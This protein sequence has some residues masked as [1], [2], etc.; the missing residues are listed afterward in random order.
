MK[1]FVV[2]IV[3]GLVLAGLGWS[4][5]NRLSEY[6][7]GATADRSRDEAPVEVRPVERG[8]IEL[9]RIFSGTLESTAE[10]VVAPKVGGRVERMVV[11][12]ADLVTRGQVVAE[13]DNDEFEQELAQAEAERVVARAKVAEAKSRLEITERELA[14]ARKLQQ[15][16]LETE[17]RFD[18]VEAER[19]AAQAGLE[20]ARAQETRAESLLAGA[21]I[22]L[23]YTRVT[24]SWTGDVDRR[25]VAR[26]HVDE[27]EMVAARTPLFTIVELDPIKAVVSVT[28]KDYA[29]L[30][31]G[32][33]AVLTT[34]AHPDRTFQGTIARIAPVFRQTSRQARVELTVPN[35]GGQL[36]PGMF[37][38]AEVVLERVE[39]ATLVPTAALATRAG[40]TGVFVVRDQGRSVTWQPVRV[41]IRDG[42]RVQVIG[43]GVSGRVVT[44]G[45]QLIDDGSRITIP[46]DQGDQSDRGTRPAAA[47]KEASE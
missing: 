23:G 43:E 45:Q 46:G 40:Q 42:E 2:M 18:T 34:D 36:K 20:V 17:S 12:L 27:G 22:R 25:I 14:R 16:G 1:R 38:R 33:Q 9:R 11:D 39:D 10:F 44:L 35:P 15:R 29:R 3:V 13:L 7:A 19:L 24:A 21:R 5:A 26:R 32:Q 8:S 41:G 31:P 37:V 47:K 28:E 4:I 30:K 6:K